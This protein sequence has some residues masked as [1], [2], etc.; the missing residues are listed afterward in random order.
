M[1][2]NNVKELI[3]DDMVYDE[4]IYD[5]LYIWWIVI[6]HLY[7]QTLFQFFAF[8]SKS[9]TVNLGNGSNKKIEKASKGKDVAV[10]PTS[11]HHCNHVLRNWSDE[12]Y[13]TAF[14]SWKAL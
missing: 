11:R 1:L 14:H 6:W 4:L 9:S 12:Q 10:H 5:F 8:T 3:Y 13:R 2:R 7:F